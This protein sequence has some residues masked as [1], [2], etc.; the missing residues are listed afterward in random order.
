M[1]HHHHRPVVQIP[2]AL[3][4]L[5][6]LLQD[7]HDHLLAGQHHGLES[8]GQVV[9]VQ[10][11]HMM[12][13]GHLVQVEVVGHHLGFPLLGQFQ[14]LQVHLA[15]RREIIRHNLHLDLLVRLHPLQHVESAAA[16][17][18]LRAVGRVG[19][20]LQFAEHKLR[21][22]EHAIDKPGLGDIGD[23]AVDDDARI[24]NF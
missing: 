12:Q 16:A 19:D 4:E 6:A 11:F 15:D 7:E 24:Q 9:D 2:Y 1:I 5:L 3:I 13:V 14:Q 10:H 18:P 21:N 23:A 20:H 22:D 8:I 17:L